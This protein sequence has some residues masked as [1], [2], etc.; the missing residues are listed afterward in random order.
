MTLTFN[1]PFCSAP[2]EVDEGK[3]SVR[4][5]YCQNTVIVPHELRG[6]ESDQVERIPQMLSMEMDLSTLI[7]QAAGFRE[8]IELARDGKLIEAIKRYRELTGADLSESKAA[9]ED[10][11]AGNAITVLST[12]TS[13]PSV[14][15]VENVDSVDASAALE[16]VIQLVQEGRKTEAIRR[17]REAFNTSMVDAQASIERI[18]AGDHKSVQHFVHASSSTPL[19]ISPQAARNTVVAGAAA[20]GG[21][22]CFAWA[23]G[24]TIALATLVPILFALASPGGPLAGVWLKVNPISFARL[25]LSFGNEGTGPGLFSDPRGVSVDREGIIY[26]AEFS[27]GRIQRFSIDGEYLS[28]WN[29][30]DESYTSSIV[31]LSDGTVYVVSRGVIQRFVGAT[32]AILYQLGT[33]EDYYFDYLALSPDG[34]L[35]TVEGGETIMRFDPQGKL[36][37]TIPSAISTVSNDSELDT[38]IAVDGLGNIYALGIFNRSV[39]KFSPQGR[40]ITRFS[41]DGDEPGQLHAPSAIAIDG[42]GRV[43]VSD[44]KGIQVFDSEG[45]YLDLING[46]GY[47]FGLAITADNQLVA[48]SNKPGVFIYRLP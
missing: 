11:S 39:F 46:D 22:G 15:Q 27:D 36:D 32:G 35:V 16:E 6:E 37:L 19:T 9:V 48:V 14:F 3:R 43:Y 45:R 10:L 44:I 34:K 1:C 41:S 21:L 18:E 2:L 23:L 17:F 26:V 28:Q 33:T 25:S 8:V 47:V 24:L 38:R 29:I 5:K 20:A 40:F 7:G 13:T 42:Q 4:C 31:A 12:L 30:G